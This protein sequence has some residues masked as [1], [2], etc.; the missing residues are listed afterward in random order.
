MVR[1]IKVCLNET[2]NGVW[3]GKHLFDILPIKNISK[4]EA[5]YHCFSTVL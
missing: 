2:Y 3:V 5:S 4:R 1:L